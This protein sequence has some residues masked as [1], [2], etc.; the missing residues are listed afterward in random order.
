MP[1]CFGTEIV[2]QSDF[3]RNFASPGAKCASALLGNGVLLEPV[4]FDWEAWFAEMDRYGAF[5]IKRDQPEP[6]ERKWFD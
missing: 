5:A 4:E 1:S 3:L 2:R 6:Q